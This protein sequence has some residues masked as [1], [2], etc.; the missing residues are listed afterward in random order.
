MLEV[1]LFT[2]VQYKGLKRSGGGT[3]DSA[4]K[5]RTDFSDLQSTLEMRGGHRAESVCRIE[6]R[7][8]N[9]SGDCGGADGY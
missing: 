7:R 8:D 9:G 1:S 5:L 6:T 2:P 4:G 3:R